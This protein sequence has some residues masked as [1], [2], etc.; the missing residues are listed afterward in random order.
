MTNPIINQTVIAQIVLDNK[1]LER[2]NANYLRY[3]IDFERDINNA[4]KLNG[5]HNFYG[6]TKGTLLGKCQKQTL[7]DIYRLMDVSVL[8]L[9]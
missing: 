5:L 2:M 6:A 8:Y 7:L 3:S 1:I 9:D 4:I